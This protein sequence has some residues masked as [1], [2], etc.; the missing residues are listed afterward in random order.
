MAPTIA[1]RAALYGPL[2]R[3]AFEA[4]GLPG[5]W[6]MALARQESAFEPSAQ[7]LIGGDKKRGG[8]FGLCQMSLATA[9]GDLGYL[10]DGDGLK[11]PEV[12]TKLAAK[13]CK[14]LT[15]R[16]K[17]T[18]LKDIAAAYN[19]GRPFAKAPKSTR[20]VYVPNVLRFAQ[21]YAQLEGN[22]SHG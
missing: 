10:G 1:E 22:D 16:L 2:I 7:C 5:H 4:E 12:N 9:Q 14:L 21:E 20:T 17:T 6:G 18:E 11:N 8:S 19:S 15:K 13:F 3:A